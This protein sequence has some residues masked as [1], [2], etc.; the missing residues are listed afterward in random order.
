[1]RKYAMSRTVH[2]AVVV[3]ALVFIAIAASC[4]H[5]T[6]QRSNQPLST[7][8]VFADRDFSEPMPHGE[9]NASYAD[10][11]HL[12]DGTLSEREI[13][14]HKQQ[15]LAS[16]EQLQQHY[17]RTFA[18]GLPALVRDAFAPDWNAWA[19][20]RVFSTKYCTGDELWYF[21]CPVSQ[22]GRHTPRRGYVI[23]RE[24]KLTAMLLNRTV[25]FH[26]SYADYEILL[27]RVATEEQIVGWKQQQFDSLDEVREHYCGHFAD[28]SPR[29]V[30]EE[31][32]NLSGAKTPTKW[33]HWH[34]FGRRYEAGDELWYFESP[35][36]TWNG[37]AG[38]CGYLVL[39]DGQLHAI[40]VVAIS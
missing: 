38:R 29:I 11:A 9:F 7:C 32:C 30:L 2:L 40:L 39:R 33:D 23:I 22:P 16:L 26:A 14:S 24:G 36:D 3:F 35:G 19:E 18:R 15:R 4:T 10:Y 20:W 34:V 28:G 8:A 37:P 6:A 31:R 1:M 12:L 17:R 13:L 25:V 27:R 21:T 5:E